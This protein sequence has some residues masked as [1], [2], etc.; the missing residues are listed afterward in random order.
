M[1]GS[2]QSTKGFLFQ[3]FTHRETHRTFK[4]EGVTL[5]G[6]ARGQSPT[7]W[8]VWT[9]KPYKPN[10]CVT[11]I[12]MKPLKTHVVF[13]SRGGG[14]GRVCVKLLSLCHHISAP[15]AGYLDVSLM[16]PS[17]LPDRSLLVL[18]GSVKTRNRQSTAARP[19][20]TEP[21]LLFPLWFYR[22]P[23][24]HQSVW[25]RWWNSTVLRKHSQALCPRTNPADLSFHQ[26]DFRGLRLL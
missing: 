24:S 20:L 16:S 12:F 26:R 21:P 10:C 3:G 17:Q 11:C 23:F 18:A 1:T 25:A 13:F 15:L 6:E 7:I 19:S 2:P 14:W 8:R 22:V 4:A 5:I 9:R